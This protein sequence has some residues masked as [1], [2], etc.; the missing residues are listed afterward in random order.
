VAHYISGCVI[1]QQ[2]FI[3]AELC[4]YQHLHKASTSSKSPAA[5]D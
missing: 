3:F 2:P 4:L 5:N 1:Y